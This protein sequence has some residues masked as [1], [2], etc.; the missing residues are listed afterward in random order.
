MGKFKD[1]S[2]QKFG[3]LTA[4]Y[5]IGKPEGKDTYYWHCICDCG[6]ECDVNG[7]SLRSGNTKSCGC[8]KFKGLK[9][10]NQ[11]Q[12]EE[13][14]IPIGQKFGK[15]TVLEDIGFV[16]H[17]KNHKR[18]AYKCLCDCGNYTIATGNQLKNNQKISCGKCTSSKGEL[19]IISILETNNILYN[20]DVV[21]QGIMQQF[22]RPLRFDFE[23][24]NNDGSLN[25]YIEFDGRQHYTGPDTSYWG[26]STD[27]LSS[28]QEKDNI[29][30]QYCINNNLILIRIPY[31]Y[32]DNLKLEDLMGDKFRIGKE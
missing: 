29:K 17:V 32:I 27:T 24:L 7:T 10:Y 19:K 13:A 3:M 2:N 1:I 18:R 16:K 12:S 31:Y 15:L 21:C 9:S 25:R 5:C 22:N 8:Q 11:K 14:L 20:H 26:H 6:T 4:L 23:I 30:N 28:I